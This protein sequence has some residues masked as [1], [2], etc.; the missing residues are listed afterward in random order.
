MELR[1]DSISSDSMEELRR[2]FDLCDE[3]NQGLIPV[4]NFIQVFKRHIGSNNV[5][6]TDSFS[7]NGLSSGS[8]E[9]AKG[10]DGGNDES[11]LSN[12]EEEQLIKFFDP[13][14]DGLMSFADFVNGVEIL[15]SKENAANQSGG[16]TYESFSSKDSNGG[17]QSF[18]E[19]SNSIARYG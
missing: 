5:S 7:S 8:E 15:R 4:S 11:T 17:D 18:C 1:S 12:E 16:T 19:V 9:G 10:A 13:D 14:S 3:F 6:S 2:I